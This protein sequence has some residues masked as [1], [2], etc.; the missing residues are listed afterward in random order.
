MSDQPSGKV[1]LGDLVDSDCSVRTKMAIP[2]AVARLLAE[3]AYDY[4]TGKC[5]N[6]PTAP[7]QSAAKRRARVHQVPQVPLLPF[8]WDDGPDGE[9]HRDDRVH[10][11]G[12]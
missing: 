3:L 5:F 7:R 12:K 2:E 9:C 4:F 10:G 11:G 8:R 1:D 6:D